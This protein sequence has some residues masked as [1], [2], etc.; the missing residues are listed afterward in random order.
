MTPPDRTLVN[1]AET[2]PYCHNCGKY[3]SEV[4]FNAF[5]WC[6]QCE[7]AV[8][9][10]LHPQPW[11]VNAPPVQVPSPTCPCTLDGWLRVVASA[12]SPTIGGA[13]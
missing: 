4:L 10:A 3:T 8:R 2:E 12:A 9:Q 5:G 6:P 13:P 11:P 7:A 1:P